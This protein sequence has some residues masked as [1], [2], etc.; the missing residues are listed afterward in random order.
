MRRLRNRYLCVCVCVCVCVCARARVCA[1]VFVCVPLFV[2]L[3]CMDSLETIILKRCR[4][5]LVLLWA[6]T[7]AAKFGVIFIFLVSL[8]L[9]FVKNCFV[10]CSFVVQSHWFCHLAMLCSLS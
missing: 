5:A 10:T 6:V 7:I 4:Y 3:C 9:M 8:S 2:L 1:C